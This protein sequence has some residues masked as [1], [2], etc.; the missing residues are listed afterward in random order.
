EAVV[1]FVLTPVL[2]AAGV[3]LLLRW[4]L[5]RVLTFVLCGLA[6]LVALAN[7]SPSDP[8]G[9]VLHLGY[10]TFALA[11]LLHPRGVRDF[12]K[13]GEADATQGSREPGLAWGWVLA[14]I[15]SHVLCVVPR[16]SGRAYCRRMSPRGGSLS[17]R[18]A[19][20]WRRQARRDR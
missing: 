18:R 5:G 7:L 16:R 2:I 11:V 14:L 17:A 9:V 6:L 12:A 10:A 1:T 19:R 15:G 13:A 3:G 8:V 4:R 20:S